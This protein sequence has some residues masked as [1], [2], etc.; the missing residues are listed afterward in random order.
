MGKIANVKM[1]NALLRIANELAEDAII[2]DSE[3]TPDAVEALLGQTREMEKDIE[4][5]IGEYQASLELARDIIV[6]FEKSIEIR[7]A[8]GTWR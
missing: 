3:A 7:K 8:N 6:K 1:Y 4:T 2:N 5:L